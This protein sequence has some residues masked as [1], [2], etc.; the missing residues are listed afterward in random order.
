MMPKFAQVGNRIINLELITNAVYVPP[1]TDESKSYLIVFFARSD[2][3][4][5]FREAEA[6]QLWRV[7]KDASFRVV[8]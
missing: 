5:I 1:Q 2:G 4:E 8:L 3:S 7:L 6:D